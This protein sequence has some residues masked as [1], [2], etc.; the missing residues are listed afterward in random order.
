MRDNG[1]GQPA[2]ERKRAN[3]PGEGSGPMTRSIQ[4]PHSPECECRDCRIWIL[5]MDM[6]AAHVR[7]EWLKARNADMEQQVAMTN[8]V[9]ARVDGAYGM[10]CMLFDEQN[11]DIRLLEAKTAGTL[12]FIA[13]HLHYLPTMANPTDPWEFHKLAR[14]AEIPTFGLGP[15]KG[16]TQ[17]RIARMIVDG[18]PPGD[19]KRPEPKAGPEPKSGPTVKAEMAEPVEFI[20][21]AHCAKCGAHNNWPR[22]G[23]PPTACPKCKVATPGWLLFDGTYEKDKPAKKR[24]PTPTVAR[25]PPTPGAKLLLDHDILD[26]IE[27]D[28]KAAQA[29]KVPPECEKC[30]R[31]NSHYCLK[32]GPPRWKFQTTK[33]NPEPVPEGGGELGEAYRL[34]S[35]AGAPTKP[36]TEKEIKAF[37]TAQPQIL[38]AAKEGAKLAGRLVDGDTEVPKEP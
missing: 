13:S 31:T 28:Q 21:K 35:E 32:C 22:D 25:V 7:I 9:A 19:S 10:M 12:Q 36:P 38:N 15:P 1:K 18:R 17:P 34:V 16:L 4:K 37:E 20:C 11:I 26:A 14:K 8:N 30:T 33:P 27:A 24:V 6:K 3:P 2:P 5:E 23:T 29:E